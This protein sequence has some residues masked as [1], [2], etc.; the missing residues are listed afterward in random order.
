[1]EDQ[2]QTLDARPD[3]DEGSV[4]H[5]SS[6]KNKKW[7]R[8][9]ARIR[10]QPHNWTFILLL[11]PSLTNQETPASTQDC[12]TV[13]FLRKKSSHGTSARVFWVL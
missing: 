1:M 5:R 4:T 3:T 9:I 11:F 2:I 6:A 13:Q 10:R 7:Q 12:R 8:L